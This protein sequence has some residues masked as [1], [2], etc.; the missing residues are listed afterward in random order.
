MIIKGNPTEFKDKSILHP[1]IRNQTQFTILNY[2]LQC[3]YGKN[4]PIKFLNKIIFVNKNSFIQNNI[5][6]G[7]EIRKEVMLHLDNNINIITIGGESYNYLF[8]VSSGIF[9]T[10]SKLLLDD[11]NY[12]KIFYNNSLKGSLIDYNKSTLKY[13]TDTCVIN[14]SKLNVNLIKNINNSKI[15]KIIIINCHHKDFWKKLKYFTNFKLKS[16]KI[17]I[18]EKIGYFISVNIFT[19]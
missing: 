15:N 19:Q 9:Y 12:N 10:N 7:H 4:I 1:L 6:I 13:N 2:R 16:R 3:C 5:K 11:F 14:L 8:F 18:D 17:F